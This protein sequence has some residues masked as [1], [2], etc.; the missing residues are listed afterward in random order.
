MSDGRQYTISRECPFAKTF[1]RGWCRPSPRR[2]ASPCRAPDTGLRPA[3]PAAHDIPNDVTIQ[4]FVK[5]EAQRL[6]V[7]WSASRSPP[8][9]TWTIRSRAAPPTRT[10]W[11]S[12]RADSTLRD[13]ATL[14]VS[15]YLD[16]F[17]NG[18]RLPAPAVASVRVA[19]QSDR[20]FVSY[21][22]ALAHVTGPALPVETEFSWSQGLLDILFEYPIQSDQS[23]FS[24]NPRLARLGIRTLTVVR[25]LPPDGS[26]RAFE[27]HGDPGLVRLDPRWHR[28]R[29][30]VRDL[31]VLSHPRRRR[32]PAVS[33]LPR[34][35]VPAP[36]IAG[37]RDHGV[38]RRAFDHAHRVR[39][40]ARAGRVVV[41][42]AHRDVDG[43]LDRV[44]GPRG[45]RLCQ[46]AERV[47]QAW[48]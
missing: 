47:W 10:C 46:P 27:F 33:G 13:A 14:W 16:L 30:A 45:H 20:S 28:G 26:V 37:R 18:E 22:E 1:C 12:S 4:T 38:H 2:R 31:G 6:R 34:H 41:S 5:P 39:V 35:A 36:A 32:P 42:A 17:E 25:F 40:Q 48:R 9:A 23:R 43:A 3:A 24:I 7:S 19:L 8:C 21:D 44:P 15:D 29:A 11:T